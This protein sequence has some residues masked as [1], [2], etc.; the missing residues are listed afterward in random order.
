MEQ[1]SEQISNKIYENNN[2]VT[3]IRSVEE[4]REA[5]AEAL[6]GKKVVSA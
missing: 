2:D 5:A 6:H 1:R 3:S 4:E